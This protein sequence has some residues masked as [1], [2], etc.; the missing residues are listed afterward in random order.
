MCGLMPISGL[1]EGSQVVPI[2][3][4][5]V[6]SGHVAVRIGSKHCGYGQHFVPGYTL[7][8]EMEVSAIHSNAATP[9]SFPPIPLPTTY[10]KWE[11]A[12]VRFGAS[13][14][15]KMLQVLPPSLPMQCQDL[16]NCLV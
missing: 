16:Y 9:T 7:L 11:S 5:P 12:A 1:K 13:I 6:T 10:N 3:L 14:T 2:G 15:K 4:T 8:M